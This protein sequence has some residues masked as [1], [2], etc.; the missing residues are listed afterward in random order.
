M[1]MLGKHVF[2]L[3]FVEDGVLEAATPHHVL[4]SDVSSDALISGAAVFGMKTGEMDGLNK[5]TGVS[6][7][8]T[9]IWTGLRR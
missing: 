5:L 2:L 3:L 1:V 7:S 9:A 8:C 6:S 4:L